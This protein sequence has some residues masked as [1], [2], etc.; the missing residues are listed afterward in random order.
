MTRM[1]KRLED[2][3]YHEAGHAVACWHLRVPFKYATIIPNA[4]ENSLGHVKTHPKPS[5]HPD[6]DDGWRARQWAEKQIMVNFAGGV[7]VKYVLGRK[8]VSGLW[9]DDHNTVE[10]SGYF[11]DSPEE[12]EAF[13][14]WLHARTVSLFHRIYIQV[15]THALAHE[16]LQRKTIRRRDAV[17]I[18]QEA[19][20]VN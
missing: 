4:D 16:L 20:R 9:G 7:A 8:R 12:E 3:A 2:T 11:A 5:F 13:L 18:I 15:A 17:A 1:S 14:K 6:I 19:I 10:V